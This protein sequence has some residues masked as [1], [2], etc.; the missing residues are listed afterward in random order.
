MSLILF[1]ALAASSPQPQ[2]PALEA[3]VR[4]YRLMADLAAAD[5]P[6]A[7]ALGM[8]AAHFFIGRIDAAAPGYDLAAAPAVP[9]AERAGLLRR[10]TEALGA[11]GFQREIGESLERPQPSA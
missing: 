8:S 9:E 6:A 10:C 11:S 5:E 2:A 4:C 7:R 3:D 1:A